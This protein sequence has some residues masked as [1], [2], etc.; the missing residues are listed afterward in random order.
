MSCNESDQ[1]IRGNKEGGTALSEPVAEL[2]SNLP[3]HSAPKTLG[4]QQM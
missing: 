1:D 2:A 3:Y 4:C